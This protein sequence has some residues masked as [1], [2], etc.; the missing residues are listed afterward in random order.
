MSYQH[1]EVLR[2]TRARLRSTRR[3]GLLPDG[4]VQLFWE[5]VPLGGSET[6]REWVIDNRSV[7]TELHADGKPFEGTW[8]LVSVDIE[9]AGREDDRHEIIVCIYARQ[10]QDAI[11]FSAARIIRA[12]DDK[13]NSHWLVA[14]WTNLD[15]SALPALKASLRGLTVT[16][17]QIDGKTWPGT[18]YTYMV[19]A[20]W[21]EDGSGVLKWT[22]GL[23][24]WDVE[25]YQRIG[26]PGGSEITEIF[27]VPKELAQSIVDAWKASNPIGSSADVSFSEGADVPN[28]VDIRL[29][30]R[31]ENQEVSF[32]LLNYPI[33]CNQDATQHLYW[34]I[35]QQR[36][37]QLVAQYAT[38]APGRRTNVSVS[39]REQDGLF[40]LSIEI[41][42]DD[43]DGVA[44]TLNIGSS[45][46]TVEE[47]KYEWGITKN[48]LDQL[49]ADYE[50]QEIGKTKDVTASYNKSNCT[51]DVVGRV[52][53][54]TG[55]VE[56]PVVF[57]R[58]EDT[59]ERQWYVWGIPDAAS[60][61]A[62]LH[63]RGFEPGNEDAKTS[64]SVNV[65]KNE[66]D[67]FNII[68]GD[69]VDRTREALTHAVDS[70]GEEQ[71]Y[72]L[73]G[74]DK[75]ETETFLNS[76]RGFDETVA[77]EIHR[78]NIS[79][80]KAANGT[81][82]AVVSISKP[83]SGS[84]TASW[85]IGSLSFQR[86]WHFGKNQAERDEILNNLPVP[87]DPG[88]LDISVNRDGNGAYAIDILRVTDGQGNPGPFVFNT[89]TGET[90]IRYFFNVPH[91]QLNG[92][93]AQFNASDRE[94]D[95]RPN[96]NPDGT[97]DV[98][99]TRR[100]NLPAFLA[101]IVSDHLFS[102]T[103]VD[104][105]WNVPEA[106]IHPEPEPEV[107][108][109]GGLRVNR[110]ADGSFDS[111]LFTDEAK[112]WLEDQYRVR[113]RTKQTTT[114]ARSFRNQPEIP[115][116][117]QNGDPGLP[118]G[119]INGLWIGEFARSYL[120]DLQQN[121]DQTWNGTWVLSFQ[122]ISFGTNSDDTG[123]STQEMTYE[124][125]DRQLRTNGGVEEKRD[126][127]YRFHRRRQTTEPGAYS[128]IGDN[129]LGKPNVY[130]ER[131]GRRV[132]WVAEW[133]TEVY[134]P[135]GWTPL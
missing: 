15:R 84:A 69:A 34:G 33:S 10:H 118:T 1:E 120:Q 38:R 2:W 5:N 117:P 126:I 135:P 70:A 8:R 101:K 114:Y 83:R 7:T 95:V 13:Q 12:K 124:F 73:F 24:R 17:P 60:V 16:S 61:L 58:D 22:A 39:F 3:S 64:R 28:S 129:A 41:V 63:D 112:P 122:P 92:I 62:Y 88:R 82:Q 45:G 51:Y 110:N 36:V 71:N 31:I 25:T 89:P 103:T 90:D 100:R 93:L 125:I 43:I 127:S 50:Q 107:G 75:E 20:E 104:W 102:R 80:S 74:G 4:V 130:P 19:E 133:I 32:S 18:H 72:Y 121:D 87:P 132:Y 48:R 85:S 109:L 91:T 26:L 11:P 42:T 68:I 97:W 119:T 108:K 49:R 14:Q 55:H 115:G 86:Y 53:W 65:F 99:V 77:G 66:D 105:K 35:T 44:L 57:E 46:T 128:V 59:T 78:R 56:V 106:E 52:S 113:G 47:R 131:I 30:K 134:T 123:A 29:S 27:N 94:M 67:T 40:D 81:Y 111:T 54:R 116:E 98:I 23:A 37:N 96:R 76:L 9:K 6:L 21:A 79:L